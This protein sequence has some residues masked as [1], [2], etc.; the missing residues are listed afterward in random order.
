MAGD[1]SD[2]N[3]L[4]EWERAG[5]EPDEESVEMVANYEQQ[6]APP[7]DSKAEVPAPAPKPAS[8]QNQVLWDLKEELQDGLSE[9]QSDQ[10][11]VDALK[12][13]AA[14]LQADI[15]ELEKSSED[16]PKIVDEYAKALT[17]LQERGDDLK[18]YADDKESALSSLLSETELHRVQEIRDAAAKEI[19]DLK[20][21]VAAL[22]K[23]YPPDFP[24]PPP[25]ENQQ[26]AKTS[27]ASAQ[28]A[29]RLAQTGY[30]ALKKHKSTLEATLKAAED[31]KKLIEAAEDSLKYKVAYY[32]LLELESMLEGMDFLTR[33]ELGNQL[34]EAWM[35][36]ASAKSEA[37]DAEE[38]FGTAKA[39]LDAASKELPEKEKNREQ[40]ILSQ[41][42]LS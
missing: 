28:E 1:G 14:A 29:L 25:P 2:A 8:E 38:H 42:N 31:R 23:E 19:L 7:P 13:T 20:D 37:R 4:P 9:I 41:I 33:S 3:R 11:R 21:L 40:T 17:G 36:V 18:G 16:I 32:H 35:A 27:L 34:G 10:A 6:G 26:A 15:K 22:S 30:E 24:S 39:K 5:E 12:K